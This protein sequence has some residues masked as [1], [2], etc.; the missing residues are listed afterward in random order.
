MESMGPGMLMVLDLNVVGIIIV[1]RVVYD[2]HDL[3]DLSG[4]QIEYMLPPVRCKG[5]RIV[6]SSARSLFGKSETPPEFIFQTFPLGYLV[7]Y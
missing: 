6:Q 7:G 3:S 5:E 1:A 4:T 2:Q